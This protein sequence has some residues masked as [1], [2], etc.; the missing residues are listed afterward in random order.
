MK[1]GRLFCC[2]NLELGKRSDL[3]TRHPIPCL[4]N[5]LFLLLLL[6]LSSMPTAA[7]DLKIG[8]FN[9]QVFGKSK[10][11]KPAVV[12]KLINTLQRYDLVLVQEVRD[13]SETA[14][15]DLLNQLNA[16]PAANGAYALVLSARLGRT[17]SKEQL[18]WFYRPSKISFV[19]EKQI[20]ELADY[21][22]RPPQITYWDITGGNGLPENTVGI[23]GIHI[24]PDEAISEINHLGPVVDDVVATGA[25]KAGVWVMG[26]LNADC[27][28]ISQT[29]WK[30][31][32]DST[33]T[34][35][36]MSLYNPTK[37]EWF[38]DDDVDTT[39]SATDCAYDRFVFAKPVPKISNVG[40]FDFSEKGMSLADIK[41]VSD[42]YPIEFTLSV[43]DNGGDEGAAP[44]S[45]SETSGAG[46]NSTN[47][48]TSGG[49]AAAS[50]TKQ[51]VLLS[52]LFFFL[53]VPMLRT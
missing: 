6:L 4:M 53:G 11:S 45:S 41:L 43:N 37:Y 47:T 23:V 50:G 19:K 21:W 12:T 14:I 34:T 2:K 13:I 48:K 18:A 40:V 7:K 15:K 32:R 46:S 24:D 27:S 52:S 39:T 44:S 1:G 3:R 36:Q 5:S 28:Y 49:S 33:C 16:P 25:A 35:T 8:A 20:S 38:I 9:V 42:H 31:I 10:M 17:N 26:D 51:N 30:C 29:K 22:E